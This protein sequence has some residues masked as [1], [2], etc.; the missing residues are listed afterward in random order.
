MLLES[1][2]DLTIFPFDDEDFK[3]EIGMNPGAAASEHTCGQQRRM[4]K[5]WTEFVR[6][7]PKYRIHL[8]L[9]FTL[10]GAFDAPNTNSALLKINQRLRESCK[11]LIE[12][13]SDSK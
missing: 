11:A 9:S 4:G 5:V 3:D 1:D 2:L 13:I 6:C 12:K 10:T 7:F 8:T